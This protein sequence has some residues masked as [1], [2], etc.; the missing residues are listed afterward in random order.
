[1]GDRRDRHVGSDTG[2]RQADIRT[3][4]GV[5]RIEARVRTLASNAESNL[6]YACSGDALTAETIEVLNERASAQ[7]DVTC[8]SRDGDFD[9]FRDAV[10]TVRFPE[11][12]QPPRE[13]SGRAL[14][15]DNHSLLLSVRGN[16]R[17]PG[18]PAE[19]AIWSEETAFAAVLSELLQSWFATHL[20]VEVRGP[21]RND[22][23]A[24]S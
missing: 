9:A 1:M 24:E 20:D 2:D 12:L 5:G 19:T 21:H 17:V 16:D 23:R 8:V 13:Q 10:Q 18:A 11:R 22:V 4:K 14:S 7:V 3:I 6:L 15:V